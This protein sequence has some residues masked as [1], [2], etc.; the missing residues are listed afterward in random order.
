VQI[1][2]AGVSLR[3]LRRCVEERQELT[4]KQGEADHVAACWVAQ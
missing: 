3:V 2:S 1:S 4:V